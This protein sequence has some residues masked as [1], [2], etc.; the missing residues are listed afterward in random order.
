MYENGL[1]VPMLVRYPGVTRPGSVNGSPWYFADFLATAM[2][3]AGRKP[4]SSTDGIPVV[5]ALRGGKLPADRPLYWELPRYIAK[6]G[7]FQDE[8]PMQAMRR[9]PWKA[10][11]PK[12]AAALELYNLARDPGERNDLAATEKGRTAE[13]D[14]AMREAR[15]TPRPQKENPHPWWDARS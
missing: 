4:P 9:G 3:L 15:T 11:R 8:L 5:P 1:R 14:A 7:T 13:F 12:A 10:V 6:T 2:E